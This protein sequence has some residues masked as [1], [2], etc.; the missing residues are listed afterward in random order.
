[1]P[2]IVDAVPAVALLPAVALVPALVLLP[3]VALLPALAGSPPLLELP[4]E[5]P[6]KVPSSSDP[7]AQTLKPSAIESVTNFK[8]ALM[9][10]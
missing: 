10:W 8:L 7:Q 9:P 3:A 4:A 2:P 1:M 6:P 5:P